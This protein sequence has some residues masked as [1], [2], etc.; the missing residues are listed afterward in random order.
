M[1]SCNNNR[2]VL[3]VLFITDLK[4]LQNAPDNVRFHSMLFS[5]LKSLIEKKIQLEL[6]NFAP[7]K[8]C[9]FRPAYGE[10]F[11]DII[12][13]YDFWAYG[14][15]DLVYGQLDQFITEDVISRHDILA[16]KKGHLHGPFTIYRNVDKINKLYTEGSYREI[17]Q[18][19]EYQSFDEFSKKPFYTQITNESEILDLPNNN[20]SVIAFKKELANRIKV[21]NKQYVKEDLSQDEVIVYDHGRVYNFHTEENYLFYHWVLE[22]R[23]IWYNYPKW[24]PEA[25][26]VFYMSISGFYNENNFKDYT[27]IHENVIKYGMRQWWLL[28]IKNYIKRRI[29]LKVSVDTYPKRGWVKPL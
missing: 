29:G 19:S 5:D 13:G 11:E 26:K 3:D 2:N 8:L 1:Q 4:P 6:P 22:K 12:H 16:F 24:L 17:F 9:D 7:Y 14:D 20:I 15:I 21:F 27:N 23:F 28:K 10:I 18:N 25:P